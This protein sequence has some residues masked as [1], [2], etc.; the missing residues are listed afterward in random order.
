MKSLGDRVVDVL[1]WSQD[2][3]LS[4]VDVCR[5]LG[6]NTAAG[7]ERYIG[8]VANELC[9]AVDAGIARMRLP[10]GGVLHSTYQISEVN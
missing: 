7:G 8:A 3:W 6:M 1:R 10:G 4:A 5:R 9:T 2:E